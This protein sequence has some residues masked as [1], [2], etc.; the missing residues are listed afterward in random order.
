MRLLVWI[1][2]VFVNSLVG[3]CY[4]YRYLHL[5]PSPTNAGSTYKT[6][7]SDLA[8]RKRSP[9][10]VLLHHLAECG[11]LSLLHTLYLD[12]FCALHPPHTSH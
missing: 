11:N 2:L 4:V 7:W 8:A 10:L 12:L 9:L 3:S 1:I 6:P 5:I